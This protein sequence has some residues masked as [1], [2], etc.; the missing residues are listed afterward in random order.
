[1]LFNVRTRRHLWLTVFPFLVKVVEPVSLLP[2][3][4]S[5]IEITASPVSS[6]K[7]QKKQPDIWNVVFG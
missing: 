6:Q 3:S 5:C 4:L 1:M 2:T 7:L